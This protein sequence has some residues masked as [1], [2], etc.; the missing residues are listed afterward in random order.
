MN[1]WI[2]KMILAGVLAAVT[3]AAWASDVRL[4]LETETSAYSIMGQQTPA[5]SG[6]VTVWISGSNVRRDE[7]NA[8][9]IGRFDDNELYIINHGERSYSRIELPISWT[10]FVSEGERAMMEQIMGSSQMDV[11]VIDTG[12]RDTIGEWSV[13]KYTIDISG[14]MG[15]RINQEVWMTTDIDID[16]VAYEKLAQELAALAPGGGDWIEEIQAI[17]GV[18]VQSDMITEVMGA[19]MRNRERLK[20][21]ETMEAPEGAFEPPADYRETPPGPEIMEGF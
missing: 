21:A 15:I 4:V 8:S 16:I 1:T 5:E 14:P 13:R 2:T 6:E 20:S 9:Y 11:V 18:A 3:I 19:E 7:D 17:E 10:D 12:E